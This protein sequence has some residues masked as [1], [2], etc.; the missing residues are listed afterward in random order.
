[1]VDLGLLASVGVCSLAGTCAGFGAGLVPGLHMNNIA[2]GLVAYSGATLAAFGFLGEVAGSSSAALLVSCFLSAALMGHLFAESITSTYL[3]IPAGDVISVLPAHRL[4]RAGLG[5][6][7]VRASADGSLCGAILAA[8]L[9]FPMCLLM[10][11]PVNLYA[12]LGRVMGF[13][14]VFVSAV[15]LYTE[16]SG[17]PK[18]RR[19]GAIAKASLMFVAAGTLGTVVLCTDYFACDIPDL[20]SNDAGF[21]SRSSLLLPLFAG[22]YGVPGLLLGLK[23]TAVVDIV[24]DSVG[25][26]V[27][28]P[29]KKDLLVSLLG[30]SMVGWMPGMTAGSSATICAPSMREFS[31]EAEV[32]G[33]ARFI[34]LYSSISASGAVFAAGALFMILRARSGCMDAAQHFL[35]DQMGPDSALGNMS[36]LAV[37]LVAMLFAASLSHLMI[38]RLNPRMGRIRARLCSRELALA[39]LAFVCSL[40]MVLTGTRGALVMATAACLGLLPPLSGVRRIQLM[41]CLLVPITIRFFGLT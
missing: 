18:A 11:S 7:A 24:C 37:M 32:R 2:A 17:R 20:P 22:L 28:F 34:W 16:G 40:S 29:S 4:A 19:A 36:T 9:L 10:G 14:I 15:L 38:S 41:G 5:E 1:M 27:H 31:G 21:V 25:T 3:G 13:I 12:L 39:S 6:V 33:S 30:G 23:S 8:V 26:T 35:G